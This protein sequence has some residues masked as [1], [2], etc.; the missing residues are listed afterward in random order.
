MNGSLNFPVAIWS[1]RFDIGYGTFDH[2]GD[3]RDGIVTQE[4]GSTLAFLMGSYLG[5][6]FS[7]VQGSCT[8]SNCNTDG[9]GVCDTPPASLPGSSC[10]TVQNS[11]STDTLSG[12]TSD[13]PDLNSNFMSL[14]GPCTN[15]FTPGQA[16]K[17]RG[18]LTT[19]RSTLL[20]ANKC[21]APCA[22]NIT[23][24]FTRDNWAPK[25]GD[26]DKFYQF[27]HRRYKLSME[28]KWC[29]DR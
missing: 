22:E 4:F 19:A 15:S 1:R 18:N 3:Y 6:K 2:I 9:D 8:N 28:C 26:P 13:M 10:T 5:L 17:M 27:I 7:F 21:D 23:A 12:F 14:S 20:S 29:C 25:T 11:C 24:G 16:A